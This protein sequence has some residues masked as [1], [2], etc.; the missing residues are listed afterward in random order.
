LNVQKIERWSNSL[1]AAGTLLVIFAMKLWLIAGFSSGVPFTDE[2]DALGAGVF[3]PY[4]EGHLT[5][6][7]LIAGDNEH[8]V[9]L[10]RLLTLGLFMWT[11]TWDVVLQMLVN[12]L[13]H[14]T[15]LVTI[16]VLLARPWGNPTTIMVLVFAAFVGAVPYGWENTLLGFN[17]HFYLLL[18]T[19]LGCILVLD[20]ARAF[21]A[22][23]CCG[24]L[25]GV[26]AFFT[27]ATG[28]LALCPPMAIAAFQIIRGQR[29]GIRELAGLALHAAFTVALF[30]SVPSTPD[31][32]HFRAQGLGQFTNTLLLIVAWPLW[33]PWFL[34]TYAT[35]IAVGVRTLLAARTL[36]DG[37]W[38]LVAVGLWL[39]IQFA[40]LAYSRAGAVPLSSR[41]L[42]IMVMGQ[43]AGVVAA[44]ALLWSPL[45]AL[46]R[47]RWL[48]I[49]V[50]FW[51]AII[52]AAD[53]ARALRTLSGPI[54][55]RHD[56][57][58][59][60]AHSLHAYLAEGD[61]T[62]LSD[63]QPNHLPYPNPERLRALLDDPSIRAALPP[64][65]TQP[66]GVAGPEHGATAIKSVLLDARIELICVGTFML[67]VG[68]LGG[69]RR[70]LQRQRAGDA[71]LSTH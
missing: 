29:R 21:S 47:R 4:L 15:T 19:S 53:G 23:W 35:L 16:A 44:G 6:S 43:I 17:T 46:R 59:L 12:A 69:L 40:A 71:A 2:W 49:A 9:L 68:A 13:I 39:G 37:G 3:K 62:A 33:R 26:L 65:L 20:G 24:T 64:T 8:R 50:A 45:M 18:A 55:E 70:V 48:L 34:L 1:A 7:D 66:N 60:Q 51:F 52:L 25:L 57:A 42:D 27:L 36:N 30:L 58:A 38:R 63:R 22:R 61:S 28:A 54:H 10:T 31:P 14:A 11:G 56:S 41:Y 5:L 32:A 67:L